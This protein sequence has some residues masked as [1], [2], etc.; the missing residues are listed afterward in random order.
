MKRDLE[1]DFSLRQIKTEQFAAFE[2]N[3]LQKEEVVFNT[4]VQIKIN[5]DKQIG[6]FLDIRCL[7][8][9]KTIIKLSVSCHFEVNEES[10]SLFFDDEKK[11]VIIPK[12]FIAYLASIT[13]GTARGILF[14]K[15]ENTI[16]SSVMLPE[17]DVIE[18][19]NKDATVPVI[20]DE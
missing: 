11:N 3:Y 9:E 14:S 17:I 16:L 10:W 15:T 12:A 4:G 6:V 1:V 2:E 18:V 20:A 19:L 7:Q 8:E 5:N 13:V